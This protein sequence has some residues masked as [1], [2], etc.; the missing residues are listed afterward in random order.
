[1]NV[2]V[3]AEVAVQNVGAEIDDR[4][5]VTAGGISGNKL[6]PIVID[7]PREAQVRDEVKLERHVLSAKAAHAVGVMPL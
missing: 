7:V 2:A 4:S 3:L 5:H 6:S 1:M